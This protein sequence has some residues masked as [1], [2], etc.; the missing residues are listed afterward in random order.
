MIRNL[1]LIALSRK[2]SCNGT[3]QRVNRIVDA[4]MFPHAV[5]MTN[6]IGKTAAG[7]ELLERQRREIA[8]A[9]RLAGALY[10]IAVFLMG[11]AYVFPVWIYVFA[12]FVW[13]LCVLFAQDFDRAAQRAKQGAQ[14]ERDVAEELVKLEGWS[15]EAGLY[16][17]NFGDIDFFLTSPNG[18]SIIIDV[19]SH[20]GEVL[21]SNESKAL[22]REHESL[23]KAFEKDFLKSAR[24]QAAMMCEQRQLK[25]VVPVI[26]FSNARVKLDNTCVNNVFVLEQRDLVDT[27]I[28]ID[29]RETRI[30][31]E[32]RH[33]TQQS[34][35]SL[36]I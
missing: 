5:L 26:V 9:L 10:A 6:C 8:V 23:S 14:G 30:R 25:W 32:R 15:V 7:P 19:K 27:L 1:A 31:I 22:V 3:S 17:E 29:A 13:R 21:Y 4:M 33:E 24:R 36:K 18:T 28:D 34:Q 12:S 16:F 20:R 11:L 2:S 35:S